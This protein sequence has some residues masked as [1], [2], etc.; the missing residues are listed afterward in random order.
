[1][2]V[3]HTRRHTR[4]LN[5][6]RLHSKS[7]TEEKLLKPPPGQKPTMPAIGINLREEN[8]PCQPTPRRAA[9]VSARKIMQ[10]I[11]AIGGM[12]TKHALCMDPDTL[13]KSEKY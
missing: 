2:R 7:T 6:W 5:E 10:A 3:S 9:L 4:F 12:V 13:L 8:T 11:R 1:M